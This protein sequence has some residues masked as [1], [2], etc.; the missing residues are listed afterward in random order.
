[1]EEISFAVVRKPYEDWPFYDG[2]SFRAPSNPLD[3]QSHC[4]ILDIKPFDRSAAKQSP[5]KQ[6]EPITKE[7]FVS[8]MNPL[9]DGVKGQ[10]ALGD[11]LFFCNCDDEPKEFES[12]EELK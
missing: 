1:M 6:D 9:P 4:A 12:L 8:I 3:G 10:E 11:F 5:R 7:D 2:D